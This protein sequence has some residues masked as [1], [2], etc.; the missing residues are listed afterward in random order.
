VVKKLILKCRQRA[1]ALDLWMKRDDQE[2]KLVEFTTYIS[3]PCAY[4]EVWE[5][6]FV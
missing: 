3:T 2:K 6:Y 1:D 4:Y 5:T